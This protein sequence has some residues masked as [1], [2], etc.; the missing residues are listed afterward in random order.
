[1]RALK[2]VS[3]D[4]R[5]R[6]VYAALAFLLS[7]CWL[8][9]NS[10]QFLSDPDVFWHIKVG[11]DLWKSGRFPTNDTYSYTFSGQPWIA[12]EWLSQ[13]ILFLTWRC[14]GWDSVVALITCILAFTAGLHC[15]F[16][17]R[18]LR[19]VVALLLAL[20]ALFL[21]MQTYLAR[22]HILTFPLVILWVEYLIGQASE[23]KVP[24][25]MMLPAMTLWANLHASFTIGFVLAALS[26]MVFVEKTLLSE[27]TK[28]YKWVL[29]LAGCVVASLIH[30]Y[31][32]QPLIATFNVFGGN[33]WLELPGEWHPVDWVEEPL[34]QIVLLAAVV[35]VLRFGVRIGFAKIA[36][37]MTVLHLFHSH[38]RFAYLYYYLMP[39]VCSHE[40]AVRS[41][42]LAAPYP[43]RRLDDHIADFLARQWAKICALVLILYANIAG[44]VFVNGGAS[45]ARNIAPDAALAFV[46]SRNISGNV[47]N[48]GEFGG[49]LIFNG[50]KTF[51]DGRTDQLFGNA[52]LESLL[53]A[54]HAGG[55]RNLAKLLTA[56]DVGWTLLL[57][58]DKKAAVLDG[59]PGW[60]RSY[61]DPYVV[62]FVRANTSLV[63]C[64]PNP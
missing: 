48:S 31:G 61:S 23:K 53:T 17:A 26:F 14:G 42:A 63:K 40:I 44:F 4:L 60:T 50:V 38:I 45:P 9:A 43:E 57:P 21:S 3:D 16:L 29:F 41:P 39:L 47:L 2:A 46:K 1:M 55:C 52:F 22:P 32:V 64:L 34:H 28:T 13:V 8:Y 30:P 20:A 49:F 25:F 59:M 24:S 5:L 35:M 58:S 12:K 33:K 36:F 7:A 19:G 11:Q 10:Q 15:F 37:V 54:G 56:Y 62:V 18:R 27:P 6:L 51:V